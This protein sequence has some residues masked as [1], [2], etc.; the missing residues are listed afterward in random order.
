M[1][2]DLASNH[3]LARATFGEADEAL[4]FALSKLCWEGPDSEL[5]RTENTQPALLTHS[6]AVWRVLAAGGVDAVAAAGHSLGEFAAHVAAGSLCFDDAVRLVRARGEAMADTGRERPG[7][8]AAILGLDEAQTQALCAEAR[9]DDEVLT[10]ANYNAPGQVVVSGSVEA[11][12][13]VVAMA[14]ECGARR[15][16]RLNVSGAF[17]SPLMEPARDRLAEALDGVTIREASIPVV[18][19]VDAEPVTAPDAIHDRL[20]DQLTAPVRWVA[21]VKRLA[22]LGATT[23]LE[24]GSG[25]VLTGLL[26][27]IDRDL[28]GRAIGTTEQVE[29]E[30]Y[31]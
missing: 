23:F 29:E 24:V 27:R 14:P 22:G 26:R 10:P 19:N 4:G 20:L 11:I 5:V 7:A 13:R 18:A 17:H 28:T 8:M 3:A 30:V 16:V 9:H 12:D 2:A 6:I 21:C 15:A 31:K 25:K 1:G